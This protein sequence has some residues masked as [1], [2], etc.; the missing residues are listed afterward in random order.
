MTITNTFADRIRPRTSRSRI[1]LYIMTNS[2]RKSFVSCIYIQSNTQALLFMCH[3]KNISTTHAPSTKRLHSPGEAKTEIPVGGFQSLSDRIGI[4]RYRHGNA[5]QCC[6][7]FALNSI[8]V[9]HDDT[10]GLQRR[11]LAMSLFDAHSIAQLHQERF[12]ILC[13]RMIH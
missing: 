4:S 11:L 6:D 3:W 12:A 9:F 2:R 8:I 10:K 7:I 13:D 5:E 1:V